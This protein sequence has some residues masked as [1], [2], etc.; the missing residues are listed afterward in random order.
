MKPSSLMISI[1]AFLVVA[2]SASILCGFI[3]YNIASYQPAVCDFLLTIIWLLL[4]IYFELRAER[5]Q[6]SRL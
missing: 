5:L 6:R 3:D 2:G 1:H 4:L